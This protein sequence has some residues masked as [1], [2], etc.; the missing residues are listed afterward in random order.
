[1]FVYL[2]I[3]SDLADKKKVMG[4]FKDKSVSLLDNHF[5]E[6]EEALSDKQKERY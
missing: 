1:M 3:K 5:S 2:R 6:Y 4:D